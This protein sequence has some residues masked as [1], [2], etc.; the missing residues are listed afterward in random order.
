MKGNASNSSGTHIFF[1]KYNS[2]IS[3]QLL[4]TH[5]RWV[6]LVYDKVDRYSMK[7]V[8]KS[9]AEA[10]SPWKIFTWTRTNSNSHPHTHSH[11]LHIQHPCLTQPD[12]AL[13][14]A[15]LKTLFTPYVHPHSTTQ[16]THLHE[17]CQWCLKENLL[18]IPECLPETLRLILGT[19]RYQIKRISLLPG[20][21]YRCLQTE[22]FCF[23]KFLTFRW[24]YKRD[25]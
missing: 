8:S 10:V 2:L 20:K 6:K 12:S 24:M 3:S 7:L 17:V 1:K 21:P 15:A 23:P 11:P 22:T 14:P 16:L 25:N 4:L 9:K 5:E 19:G 13:W 18:T